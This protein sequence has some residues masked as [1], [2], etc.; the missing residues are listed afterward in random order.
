M[1]WPPLLIL[2]SQRYTDFPGKVLHT[3]TKGQQGEVR[4]HPARD[5]ISKNASWLSTE[6][7]ISLEGEVYVTHWL[8]V[9]TPDL[10]CTALT[11][12]AHLL[13]SIWRACLC[14][15]CSWRANLYREQGWFFCRETR[16]Q[17]WKLPMLYPEGI[18]SNSYKILLTIIWNPYLHSIVPGSSIKKKW[19]KPGIVMMHIWNSSI[20]TREGWSR[21]LSQPLG[22]TLMDHTMTIRQVKCQ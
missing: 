3:R 20:W 18:H 14:V 22:F 9:H 5:H 12:S 8:V 1:G 17:N 16:E 10:W 2:A 15:F 7:A 4:D 6:E 19:V 21:R 13:A 11:C